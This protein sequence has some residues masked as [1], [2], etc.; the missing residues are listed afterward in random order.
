MKTQTRIAALNIDLITVIKTRRLTDGE[1]EDLLTP[2]EYDALPNERTRV[3]RGRARERDI[4]R[5]FG[6]TGR[7]RDLSQ[8]AVGDSVLFT[9]YTR[10]AQLGPMLVNIS[11]A[12]G[13]RFTSAVERSLIDGS[14]VGVRVT[15]VCFTR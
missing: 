10:T 5:T 6:P 12:E 9:E 4:R 2:E 11:I 13:C 3:M 8:G 15:L 1:C 7:L 14:I